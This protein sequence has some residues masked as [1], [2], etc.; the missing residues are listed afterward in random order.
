MEKLNE[1]KYISYNEYKEFCKNNNIDINEK[2]LSERNNKF[3]HKKLIEY[4]QYFDNIFTDVGENIKLDEEQRKIILRDDDYCLINAGA[5]SGKST[6]M[7]A[8]V[9]Y[10]VDK[11]KVI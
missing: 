10:L 3:I 7:A 1:D 11:I 5:G 6:T 4:N 2:W 9:K 8:K